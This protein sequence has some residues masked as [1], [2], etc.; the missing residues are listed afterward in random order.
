MLAENGTW[1]LTDR[2]LITA[3]AVLMMLTFMVGAYGDP[4][5]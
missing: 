4:D 1:D 5:R 2:I 3:M